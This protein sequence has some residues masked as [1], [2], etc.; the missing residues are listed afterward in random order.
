MAYKPTGKPNGRPQ[1]I[2]EMRIKKLEEV[3]AIGGTDGE[4]CFYAEISPALLY[5]YQLNHPEFVERKESL[6]K[7]PFLLARQTVVKA[8]GSD[9]D[10][11]LKY[12]ERKHK[13]EFSLRQE[14]TGKDGAPLPVFMPSEILEKNGIKTGTDGN[15]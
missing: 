10:M 9:P 3:F 4:A 11:A 7:R 13:D 6:K 8:V 5:K 15:T 2:D 12:L 14:H 1:K